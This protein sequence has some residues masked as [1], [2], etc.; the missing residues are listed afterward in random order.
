MIL[1]MN[2]FLYRRALINCHGQMHRNSGYVVNVISLAA[3][4]SQAI[5]IPAELTIIH[6]AL[7][8]L[9][10]RVHH[11]LQSINNLSKRVEVKITAEEKTP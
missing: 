1:G 10:D 7:L 2:W 9:Q 5:F 11:F 6:A 4:L 8:P 3:F